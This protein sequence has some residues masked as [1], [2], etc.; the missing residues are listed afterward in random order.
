[1]VGSLSPLVFISRPT[2]G[3][4]IGRPGADIE[5]RTQA[6]TGE[7]VG[8][9]T[10]HIP[11][12]L[13]HFL[14]PM[15]APRRADIMCRHSLVARRLP[16]CSERDDFSLDFARPKRRL[17]G[18]SPVEKA[19]L[20]FLCSASV[21]ACDVTLDNSNCSEGSVKGSWSLSK[22]HRQ[23]WLQAGA[24]CLRLCSSCKPCRF[25]SVS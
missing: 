18:V 1:M 15:Q 25:I 16:H 4:P 5:P 23:S 22:E 12:T 20:R 9:Q 13:A 10:Y 3:R 19:A 2:G 17:P 21:G 8:L 7:Q 6:A 11:A 24:E 14:H